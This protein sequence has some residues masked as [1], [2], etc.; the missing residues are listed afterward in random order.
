MTG[1]F[2][3]YTDYQHTSIYAESG[4]LLTISKDE[5]ISEISQEGYVVSSK[6]GD[7]Y[8]RGSTASIMAKVK[9]G[10]EFDGW[11]K[12]DECISEQI[13][14]EYIVTESTSLTA[15]TKLISYPLSFVLN[16]G[17]VDVVL[18]SSYT[19]LS[20]T[21]VLP[22]PS[23]DGYTF[24]G[25]YM[26]PDFS[27]N[28]VTELP[29]GSWGNK[30]YYA[31]W[32]EITEKETYALILDY[33][34][35]GSNRYPMIFVQSAVPISAGETYDSK[36]YGKQKVKY[37]YTGFEDVDY[38]AISNVVSTNRDSVIW[39]DQHL[40]VTSVVIEDRFAPVSTAYW[41]YGFQNCKRIDVSNLD[42]SRL[43][44]TSYG[45]YDAGY[46]TSDFQLIGLANW[47]VSKV[48]KMTYMF[49]GLGYETTNLEI[50]GIK[51]WDVSCVTDM[52]G[53][54][55]YSGG[56]AQTWVID[57]LSNWN[58]GHVENMSNMFK[59][60][61]YSAAALKIGGLDMWDV[62]H[63]TNMS[64]MFNSTGYR[65]ATSFDIGDLSQWDVSAVE[66]M[67]NMFYNAG[68]NAAWSLDL[69][70]WYV[71]KVISYAGFNQGVTTKVT[72]PSWRT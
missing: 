28:Q 47:N 33:T 55:E 59:H 69:S 48:E 61:G 54:F 44:N 31:K 58:V 60:A 49:G 39:F 64:S 11:F 67:D 15:K 57:D 26:T 35:D 68:R 32:E 51:D 50:T 65:N 18:P 45:F 43:I 21:I 4:S 17:S 36:T 27:S 5:G 53:M 1:A 7:Q 63:V 23:R 2:A 66:R 56:Y 72:A 52:S 9:H 41:F 30:I 42:T 13:E 24:E 70:Q 22:I 37:A 10:Y 8:K 3:I 71:A 46:L 19:I 34:A 6:A 14:D 12:Q 16:G 40:L 29:T 20:E 25:W 38:G 62:S